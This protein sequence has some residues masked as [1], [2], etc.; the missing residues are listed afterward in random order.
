MALR[1]VTPW[2]G[3][4]PHVHLGLECVVEADDLRARTHGGGTEIF[5]LSSAISLHQNLQG[6]FGSVIWAVRGW[7]SYISSLMPGFLVLI[8]WIPLQSGILWKHWQQQ[9]NIFS[10]L[11]Q[12]LVDQLSLPWCSHGSQKCICGFFHLNPHV[13]QISLL[14]QQEMSPWVMLMLSLGIL[15]PTKRL[16]LSKYPDL[17]CIWIISLAAGLNIESDATHGAKRTMNLATGIAMAMW[18]H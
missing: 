12:H 4:S 15:F 3:S 10:S 8:K 2:L 6:L 11:F 18:R 9:E 16:H 1:K 14:I 5:G 7:E 17:R 13:L